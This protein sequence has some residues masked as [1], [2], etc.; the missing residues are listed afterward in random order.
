MNP[1]MTHEDGVATAT[2]PAWSARSLAADDEGWDTSWPYAALRALDAPCAVLDVV[3]EQVL[4]CAPS[5]LR[6]VGDGDPGLAQ[7][8]GRLQ[9]LE[10]AMAAY[11]GLAIAHGP[12]S[13]SLRLNDRPMEARLHWLDGSRLML[14]LTDRAGD[15]QARQRHLEDREQL[16]FTS[17]MLSIGEMATTLAHEINQPIGA[18]A[19]LLRGVLMRM[20]RQQEQPHAGGT[21]GALIQALQRAVDQVM[22]ASKVIARIREYTHLHTP[23]RK[24][25]DVVATV[26]ACAGLLDWETEREGVRVSFD[27][28][29]RPLWIEA[30]ELMLQ[31][32]LVNLMR[33]AI[34]AMRG[35]APGQRRLGLCVRPDGPQV[36]VI[37][38]D[39]GSGISVESEESLF[40]PFVSSKPTGTGIGLNIC[41]SFIELHR[42]RLWFSRNPDRGISFHASLPLNAQQQAASSPSKS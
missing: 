10:E 40:T 18:A 29:T 42:G 31:Q 38:C 32:V 15:A 20:E 19:N 13:A 6:I 5:F 7:L 23:Q 36:E 2:R 22:F 27:M 3:G 41:R 28:P 8:F 4:W 16:L 24:A 1:N 26:R 33:N 11:S 12:R 37:V 17:R 21:S 25:V 39:S 34:D 14:H 9:G 30:D 35:N